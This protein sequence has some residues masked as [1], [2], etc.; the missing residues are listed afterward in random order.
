MFLY[1]KALPVATFLPEFFQ[2]LLL[3]SS[4][5]GR[6]LRLY[7]LTFVICNRSETNV[8]KISDTTIIN[9]HLCF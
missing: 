8:R 4:Q 7:Q 2:L 1:G 6:L 9:K 5:V 3:W